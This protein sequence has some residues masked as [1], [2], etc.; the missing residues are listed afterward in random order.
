M[1]CMK[2]LESPA[3]CDFF[4]ALYKSDYI[5]R[6]NKE[7]DYE[8]ELK[9]KNGSFPL[10][11]LDVKNTH[12]SLPMASI[13]GWMVFR[14][15]DTQSQIID[16]LAADL[17]NIQIFHNSRPG[18]SFSPMFMDLANIRLAL[19]TYKPDLILK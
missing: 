15:L 8:I 6:L 18:D 9:R 14:S 16:V 13:M 12:N 2:K 17:G 11:I 10:W 1:K 4:G 19:N 7:F 5:E 3:R